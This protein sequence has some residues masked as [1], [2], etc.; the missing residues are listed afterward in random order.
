MWHLTC[1]TACHQGAIKMF[2]LTRGRSK[3]T[4]LPC[5]DEKV[6][7]FPII[8]PP[9]SRFNLSVIQALLQLCTLMHWWIDWTVLIMWIL[10][11]KP[12][13]LVHILPWTELIQS[14]WFIQLR[15]NYLNGF[16]DPFQGNRSHHTMYLH[17]NYII[18]SDFP[19]TCSLMSGGFGISKHF[20]SAD[21]EMQVRL[22]NKP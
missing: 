10:P 11:I 2:C 1:T 19:I 12:A 13:A 15:I 21:V 7:A 18:E 4:T 9:L 20:Q 16:I 3:T 17:D 5:G 14:R 6:S 8:R 22:T